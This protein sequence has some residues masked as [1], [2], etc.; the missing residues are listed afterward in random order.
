MGPMCEC[1]LH[2]PTDAMIDMSTDRIGNEL[3]RD[4]LTTIELL[5]TGVAG[6][7]VTAASTRSS[8]CG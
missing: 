4:T 1:S 5:T 2:T 6:L 3:L 8:A 7:G